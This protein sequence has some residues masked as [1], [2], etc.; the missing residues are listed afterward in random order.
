MT[1]NHANRDA[2]PVAR[3][4]TGSPSENQAGP[5]GRPLYACVYRLP[6]LDAGGAAPPPL[7]AIAEQFSPRYE[8]HGD[9]LLSIDVSGLERLLGAPRTIGEELRREA[10]ERG[11]RVHVAVARRRMVALVLAVAQPGLTVV[12]AGE[13]AAALAPIRIGVLE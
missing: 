5:Y 8:R 12:G 11:L 10:A 7:T 6:A 4:S 3:S 1:D 9:D 13:E 2:G